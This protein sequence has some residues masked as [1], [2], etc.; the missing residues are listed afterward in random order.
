MRKL[1]LEASIVS[2]SFFDDAG[3]KY[4]RKPNDRHQLLVPQSLVHDVIRENHNPAYGAHPGVKRTCDLI[5]LHIWWANLRR[6]VEGY[7]KECD[8]CQRRKEN[9]EFIEPLGDSEVLVAPFQ[10]TAMDITGPYPLTPHRNK[11]ILTIIDHYT[12]YVQAFA[13]PDR[14]AETCAR[15]YATQIV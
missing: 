8:A 12:K 3:I 11:Y 9:R 13:M 4:R 6:S 7:V 15:V 14:T 5:A 10:V 2:V 1:Y